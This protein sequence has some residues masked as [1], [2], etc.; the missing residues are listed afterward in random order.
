[1]PVAQFTQ[2]LQKSFRGGDHAALALHR[3]YDYGAGIVI[4]ER[5]GGVQIV[6]GCMTN[7]R[8]QRRKVL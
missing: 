8:R 4:N 3:L 7:I 2:P 1:M 6:I 5:A